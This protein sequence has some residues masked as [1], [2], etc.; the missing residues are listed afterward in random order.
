MSISRRWFGALTLSA[1]SACTF[2]L[3]GCGGAA[4]VRNSDCDN[5]HE[6][7]EGVCALPGAKPPAAGASGAGGAAGS[8]ARAGNGGTSTT[9]AGRDGAGGVSAGR[10]GGAGRANGGRSGSSADMNGG[11]D[12]GTAGAP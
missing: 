10:G 11:A 12:M 1:F 9:N 8:S 4:C 6:C 2:L 5:E 3:T 7:H